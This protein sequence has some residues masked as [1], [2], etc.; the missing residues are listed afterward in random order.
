MLLYIQATYEVLIEIT[1]SFFLYC[2][3]NK[4]KQRFQGIENIML[5][6]FEMDFQLNFSFYS[7]GIWE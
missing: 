3:K 6:L 5:F 2:L 4:D 1:I 7:F